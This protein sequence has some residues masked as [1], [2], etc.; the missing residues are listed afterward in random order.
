MS[1]SN[2]D[3]KMMDPRTDQPDKPLEDSPEKVATELLG[4]GEALGIDY[5]LV[6]EAK[7]EKRL[8][9]R[10]PQPRDFN[11][12]ASNPNM[13]VEEYPDDFYFSIVRKHPTE[14]AA[15]NFIGG[16]TRNRVNHAID[17]DWMKEQFPDG[18]RYEVQF[19]GPKSGKGG[20]I[21]TYFSPLSLEYQEYR[22]PSFDGID[23]VPRG[24]ALP[25]RTDENGNDDDDDDDEEESPIRGTPGLSDALALRYVESLERDK[26]RAETV[27][28]PQ[29]RPPVYPPPRPARRD[30]DEEDDVKKSGDGQVFG[31]AFTKLVEA[32]A[33]RPQTDTT[34]RDDTGDSRQEVLRLHGLLNGIQDS[35]RKELADRL[36]EQR[37]SLEEMIREQRASFEKL[38]EEMRTQQRDA[39]DRTADKHKSEIASIREAQGE[40]VDQL[41]E[42]VVDLKDELRRSLDEVSKLRGD[43]ATAQADAV[44][45]K[46]ELAAVRITKES[47]IASVKAE[48]RADAADKARVE[49]LSNKKPDDDDPLG[50]LLNKV[51]QAKQ[52]SEKLG[53]SLGGG[54][55]D[56]VKAPSRIDQLVDVAA[57]VAGSGEIRKLAGVVTEA[58]AKGVSAVMKERQERRNAATPS[59]D[60]IL[61]AY[62][63]GKRQVS[64][65]PRRPELPPEQ[66]AKPAVESAGEAATD[67]LQE[68]AALKASAEE[69]LDEVEDFAATDEPVEKATE[70]LLD[71]LQTMAGASRREILEKIKGTTA[72]QTLVEL[73]LSPT[74]LSD[75]AQK[76]LDDMIQH[77]SGLK[78]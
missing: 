72:A 43:L 12:W 64:S 34:P 38:G 8:L 74:R 39:L 60:A 1:G 7:A 23:H 31:Q 78:E 51:T 55:S 17:L 62:G 58:A 46:S 28:T 47:E 19:R 68:I 16:Y 45:S 59:T 52:L 33:T 27:H 36:R 73:E 22:A 66:K 50:S 10:E 21:L 76:Y 11:A 20:L 49:A 77:A 4:A 3:S 42:R 54:K 40:R 26:R 57:K 32:L 37:E 5:S 35:H 14:D 70:A 13:L 41:K 25:T 63:R 65:E 30:D 75:E 71:R 15:G 29:M 48:A 67:L 69:M 9:R 2:P 24:N 61:A 44:T 6:G 56:T 53:E 18:G